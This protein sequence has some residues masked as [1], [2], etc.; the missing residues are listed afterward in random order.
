MAHLATHA[1]RLIALSSAPYL[2]TRRQR[3]CHWFAVGEAPDLLGVHTGER[4]PS[5]VRDAAAAAQRCIKVGIDTALPALVRAPRLRFGRVEDDPG[6]RRNRGWDISEGQ[7]AG[8]VH[9]LHHWRTRFAALEGVVPRRTLANCSA[10]RRSR[11]AQPRLKPRLSM[12]S[13]H[14]IVSDWNLGLSC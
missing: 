12:R 6:W 3:D 5:T 14:F 7:S 13:S 1:R 9:L 10:L 4:E 2:A 8:V 11:E